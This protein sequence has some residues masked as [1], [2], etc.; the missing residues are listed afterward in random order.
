MISSLQSK[1][2]PPC[3]S[4]EARPVRRAVHGVLLLDKP[5]QLSSNQALQRAKRLFRAAK[6]GHTGSLDPLATG[7]LP[8]CFGE[9]TKFSQLL[10]E[11]DKHYNV[12]LQLGVRTNTGD[13]EGEVIS[14]RAVP[15]FSTE[16]LEKA[17]D[18]FRGKILQIP[19]MY[20]AIKHQG[21][22]L[23]T[24]ARRGV[25]IERKAREITISALSLLSQQGTILNLEVKASKG[26]YIRS[27]VDDLGEAL[28]CGA[29]VTALR[30]L[31]VGPYQQHSMITF[32]T[33]E[34]LLDTQGIEALH[35]CLLPME[36]PL[37]SW[38][39]VV[40]SEAAYYYLSRGQ[41]VIVPYAPTS[42][43]VRLTLRGK[44]FIG[45]GEMIEGYRVAPK[46]L[47]NL[48]ER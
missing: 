6:A 16:D 27:L 23:Y 47:V 8:I 33:L 24:Y 38:P 22:P 28:G 35:A 25:D 13:A 14:S 37:A 12:A 48:S 7:L 26:T 44:G 30:R 3:Y 18:H 11:A 43:K 31:S 45:V 29:H 17:L 21:K 39:E 9:A 36:S 15:H 41:S 2:S 20:S 19:P 40:L 46:R 5:L 10:L 42:G 4:V 32:E 1:E 34:N